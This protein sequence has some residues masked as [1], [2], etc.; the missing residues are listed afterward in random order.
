MSSEA[1][2]TNFNYVRFDV[3]HYLYVCH[4]D[5]IMKFE[6]SA[7]AKYV[8]PQFDKRKSESDYIVIDRDGKHFGSILNYMRDP[9]SLDLSHWSDSNL[10]DLMREADYYCLNSLVQFCES[11][12]EFRDKQ[13]QQ[14]NL[15]QLEC[16]QSFSI[17]AGH[18]LEVI[19][20]LDVMIGLLEASKKPTIV[21]SYLSMRRLHID[22]WVEE[23]LKLCDYSKFKV[24]CFANKETDISS[25]PFQDHRRHHF[26]D[27]LSNFIMCL[28]DPEQ[29]R[30][31]SQVSAPAYDR[32]RT[33]RSHYKCKVFKFWFLIQNEIASK[34][35]KST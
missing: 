17:P 11:E 13:Q 8:S 22:S 28:Y 31:L 19:F 1:A 27:T 32:F 34:S 23:L 16:Q 12:F 35:I 6:N 5:T 10:T 29:R 14:H 3:G 9:T 7:L 26:I 2:K 33:K 24:Y 30:F 4:R 15:S 21:I 20:G 25:V 18:R